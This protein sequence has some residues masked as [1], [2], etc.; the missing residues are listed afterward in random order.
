MMRKL[1]NVLN[2]ARK[3]LWSLARDPVMMGLIVYVF[4]VA[5]YVAAM[6]IPETLSNAAIA[7]VDEDASPLSARIAQA[8]YPPEFVPPRLIGR[9][10]MDSGMDS[11]AFTFALDVPPNFQRDVLAGRAPELQL[12]VD[13]TRMSQAFSGASYV[14]QM[15]LL[16]VS[17]FVQRQRAVQVAPVELALRASFNP[18]LTQKWFGSVGQLIDMVGVLSIILTG[19][20]LM[21]EREHGTVEH[22]LVM[23]VTPGE[24]MLSK[25]LAMGAVVLAAVALSMRLVVAGWLRVPLAG[26]MALFLLGAALCIYAM[27]ALG[28]FMATLA[29]SMPQFGMLFVLVVLPLMMLSGGRTSRDGMPE[30]V[31]AVMRLAPTTHFV[32]V[33]QAILF[34]GAGLDVVWPSLLAMAAIG[35]VLFVLALRRFRRT[36]AQMG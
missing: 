16:E 14:Q 8:F 29:R 35:T 31:R 28:I 34:R 23:P 22:L 17:E 36:L 4:T 10:E 18:T 9:A 3:E 15:A 12:N 30:A 33:G 13:A 1:R 24:I 32:D 19:A 26:S 21:R 27:T 6:A 11:G 5:I 2:L 20:A 25:V 7:I